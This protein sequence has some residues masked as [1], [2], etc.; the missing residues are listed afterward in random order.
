M[1]PSKVK[2]GMQTL[3]IGQTIHFFR[4]LT[5]TNDMA[6]ELALIEAKEGTVIVAET[7]TQGRGRLGRKWVSPKGG[8]WFSI[9]LRP[10]ISVEDARKLTLVMSVAVAKTLSKMF[11][12]EAEIKWPNDVLIEGRKVCGILTEANTIEK[13]LNFIVVGVGT[14]ANF[15]LQDLPVNIRDSSTTLKEELNNEI[16]CQAFLRGLLEETERYYKAFIEGEFKAVLA[17]WRHFAKFL[18]SQIKVTSLDETIEGWATD[19]D[20]NGALIIK[21]TDQTIRK[22]FSGDVTICKVKRELS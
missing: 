5:S 13:R 21:L 15:N 4:E 17:E 2:A 3:T 14:N 20:E 11:N 10:R 19:I 8:L 1:N 9:I 6:K 18:G 22:V 12:L 16:D 7:Q